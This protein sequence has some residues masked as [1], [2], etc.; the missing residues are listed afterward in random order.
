MIW[1]CC[2]MHFFIPVMILYLCIKNY[3][4]THRRLVVTQ[5]RLVR[6]YFEYQYIIYSKLVF[7]S[8]IC[9]V[10]YFHS[11]VKFRKNKISRNLHSSTL[12]KSDMSSY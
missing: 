4:L 11:T 5:D 2:V 10:L 6:G 9:I 12:S 1:T 8:N 7:I 3:T